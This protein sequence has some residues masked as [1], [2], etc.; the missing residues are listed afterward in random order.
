VYHHQVLDQFVTSHLPVNP[1]ECTGL[2]T[3]IYLV[4]GC[5]GESGAGKT[6]ASKLIMQASSQLDSSIISERSSDC[7]ANLRFLI[8]LFITMCC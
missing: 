7:H 4:N 3:L 8:I 2:A 6:E 5:S 1:S